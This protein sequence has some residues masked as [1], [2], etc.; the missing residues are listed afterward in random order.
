LR[1]LAIHWSLTQ[2][3]NAALALGLILAAL[4]IGLLPLS[5]AFATVL[6][7]FSLLL[8]LARLEYGLVLLAF[9]VPFGSLG[10]I[11]MADF[12]L[13]AT[14]FIVPL[15]VFGW[16]MRMVAA[17]E[18][19]ISFPWIVWPLALFMAAMALSFTNSSSLG[20]SLKE[21]AKW[22]EFLAVLVLI[23]NTIREKSQ[24]LL[25][26]GAVLAAGGLAAL[27]GWY[28]FALRQ[29]PGS[30]LVAET[31]LRAYGFYGQ[32]NPFAGYLLT[33][34]P[35]ALALLLA[36]RIDGPPRQALLS[37]LGLVSAAL[38]MTLS[39]GGLLGLAAASGL[40]AILRGWVS[41]PLLLGGLVVLLFFGLALSYDLVPM[42]GGEN[43]GPLAEFGI[44]DPRYVTLTPQNFSVVERMALWYAGWNIWRDNPWLGV[45]IGN[46]R[47]AYP[48]YALPG[49]DFGQEH[50]HNYYFN[51]MVEAGVVGL[52][53][54]LVFLGSLFL[55]ATQSLRASLARGW[56][57]RS[58]VAVSL[59]AI[60][61]A[62]SIHNFFDNIYV[63]G[64]L[65]QLGMLLGLL[66]F[67]NGVGEVRN[68][69]E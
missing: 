69:P 50:V 30:F 40:M 33:V 41:K 39:R 38:L 22:L 45:G 53:A 43:G 18:A 44:F 15:V 26:L 47:T 11:E 3:P 9:T 67:A 12:S 46:F 65:V 49:W 62:L 68:W 25:I 24:V 28:Q 42:P 8:T 4:A 1:A 29:G 57:L 34:V 2:L 66:P 54:Y 14:E 52:A 58:G 55:Y 37:V 5:L 19:R 35:V 7:I 32:P 64:M 6:G 10:E 48:P 51:L 63:H 36:V 20:L 16:I 17:R 27:H 59:L 60:L 13:S 61:L 56:G 23:G 31:F 21:M